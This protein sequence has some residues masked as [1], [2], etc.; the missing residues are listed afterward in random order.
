VHRTRRGGAL[1]DDRAQRH[2]EGI[3]KQLIA[4][5]LPR[6]Q[7]VIHG[8]GERVTSGRA[9]FVRGVRANGLLA[10]TKGVASLRLGV[11]QRRLRPSQRTGRVVEHALAGLLDGLQAISRAPANPA[12]LLGARRPLER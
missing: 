10:G 11:I 4:S 2:I 3:D 9:T 12:R 7:A 6:G 1:R 8:A 5:A